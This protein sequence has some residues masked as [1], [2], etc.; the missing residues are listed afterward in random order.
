MVK[1][2]GD[3]HQI[4]CE[5]ICSGQVAFEDNDGKLKFITHAVDGI[6]HDA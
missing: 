4:L 5:S 6:S 1:L 2:V 3:E